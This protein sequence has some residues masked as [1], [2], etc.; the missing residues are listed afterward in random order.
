[1]L[2]LG[3]G[4]YLLIISSSATSWLCF[5]CG[6]LLLM[7]SKRLAAIKNARRVLILG[8]VATGCLLA[9]EQGFQ[10]SNRISEA[11]G[12]G[13]GMS[14]RSN[15]WRI[16][17][18]QSTNRLLGAG[19]H[20][21]WD[22]S[23]GRA[24]NEESGT[25]DLNTA[26]NGFLETYLDGG[27]VGLFFLAVFIW[28]IGLNATAKLIDGGPFGRMAIVFWPLLMIYNLSESQFMIQGPIW[29][30]VLLVTMETPWLKNR[31]EEG[32]VRVRMARQERQPHRRLRIGSLAM[33]GAA[34][35]HRE[36]RSREQRL[37]SRAKGQRR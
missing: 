27:V 35:A 24:V 13:E 15:I 18:E 3:I 23:A 7:I 2:N 20:V 5:L 31:S 28:S 37:S 11:F 17:I 19:F 22:T 10:L 29:F 25:G 9:L 32:T 34:A 6:L 26:H 12:R 33:V 8:V 21:F 30:I 16:A 4:L 1:V 14:G 36:I